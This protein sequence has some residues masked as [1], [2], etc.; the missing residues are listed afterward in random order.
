M[1]ER[2]IYNTYICN[3]YGF[4]AHINHSDELHTDFGKETV[5]EVIMWVNMEFV[6]HVSGFGFVACF[7]L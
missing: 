4:L 3:V 2:Y 5:M 1:A 6:L 7:I